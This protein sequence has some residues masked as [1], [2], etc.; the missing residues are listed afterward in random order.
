MASRSKPRR[1]QW[2][3]P[4]RAAV[5]DPPGGGQHGVAE[6]AMQ[7][8]HGAG[9]DAAPEPVAHD[10]LP[11]LA[12]LLDES[13]EPAEIV[14][15]VAVAHDD[16]AAPRGL[17]AADQR[18]AVAA[19]GDRHHARAEASRRSPASRRCC[20]CRRSRPRRRC[21]SAR[22]SR[23]PSDAD[24][25]RLGLVQAGHQDGEFQRNCLDVVHPSDFLASAVAYTQRTQGAT[26]IGFTR[27]D[28][29]VSFLAFAAANTSGPS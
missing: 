3:S 10:E 26:A 27:L 22:G 24:R 14:A 29:R 9:G 17:D 20:R 21:R 12:Q 1:P 8:R 28:L 16:V 7:R 15:V 4:R 2:K 6:V 23:A 25:E 18:R 11:A 5:E 19:L 13:V